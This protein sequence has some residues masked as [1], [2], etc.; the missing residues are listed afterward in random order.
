MDPGSETEITVKIEHKAYDEEVERPIRATFAGV[1]RVDPLAT[2]VDAAADFTY[3]AANE[4]Q[5]D[6]TITWRT[7]SNRGI[8]ERSETYRVEA[9][10]RLDVDWTVTFRQAGVT[11]RGTGRARQLRVTPVPGNPDT[12][13][14]PGVTVQGDLEFRGR[15]RTPGCSGGYR[16]SFAVDPA[17]DASAK[18]VGEGGGRRLVVALRLTDP[19]ATITARASCDGRTVSFG[20]PMAGMVP[21]HTVELPLA[22][23]TVSARGNESGARWTATFTLTVERGR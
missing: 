15:A 10:Y 6:G 7:V 3:T 12:G 21:S 4:P 19:S 18:I 16:D 1:E 13:E 23:G 14:P 8:A 11:A 2:P 5:T 22:G 9:S 20:I 17:K